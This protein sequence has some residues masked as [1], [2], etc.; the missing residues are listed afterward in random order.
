MVDKNCQSQY[1]LAAAASSFGRDGCRSLASTPS[2][3]LDALAPRVYHGSDLAERIA[4]SGRPF[5]FT[6]AFSARSAEMPE[7]FP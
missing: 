3:N 2:A 7:V 5:S 4:L 1:W 6:N